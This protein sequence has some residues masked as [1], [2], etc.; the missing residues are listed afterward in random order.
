MDPNHQPIDTLRIGFV[1]VG[2]MGTHHVKN[3]VRMPG[4]RISA[5]CDIR[6][7]HAERAAGIVREAGQPAPTLYTRGE[8]DFERLC[9]EADV[10]LVYTA[11]PWEWHTPVCLTAMENGKHAATEVPAAV[12]LEECWQLV[13]TAE[14]TGQ[15]C[16]IAENCCYDRTEM[17][18]LNMVRQGV[19]GEL[20]HAEC[21]YLHDL[22][23]LLFTRGASPLWRLAHV[24]E[25]DGDL[26]PTHGVGPVAQWLDINR[27]NRFTRLVSMGTQA[28]G[29]G[30]YAGRQFGAEC[31]E[32]AARYA[33][34]DIVTSLIQTAAGQTVQ[35]RHD[36]LSPRPYSRGIVLQGTGG[37]VRKYPEEKIHLETRSEP[38]AW[39][40]LA[41]YQDAYE[42]PLWQATMSTLKDVGGH[43]N[44]DYLV[45]YRLT[46]CLR[47]GIAPDIDVYD[48]ATWSAISAL[49][50]QSI[51][52]GSEPV[53]FPGLHA[54]PLA[55]APAAGHR[56]RLV[57]VG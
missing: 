39:E 47:A 32:A 18:I 17:M 8:R 44:M 38:E 19:L 26:Y 9:A 11:T 57:V 29:L 21:G 14:R 6:E 13:D 28:R 7:D 30:L 49:S 24:R 12:T 45:D 23:S 3:L 25:R 55:L 1:G 4:V 15:T 41:D 35:M 34:S 33:K 54:R 42:H 20:L 51:A 43:G 56:D 2:G 48:A 46:Q 22:R 53:E 10:H 5:L 31:A 27:G 16:F 52:G 40:D 37:I 36:T 50:E